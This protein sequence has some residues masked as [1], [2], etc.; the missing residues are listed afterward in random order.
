MSDD[1]SW[2]SQE[3]GILDYTLRLIPSTL[4]AT[5]QNRSMVLPVLQAMV[6][7][8]NYFYMQNRAAAGH[9]YTAAAVSL[10]IMCGL[11]KVNSSA[12]G[13]SWLP[14]A[15]PAE[16]SERINGWW[17]IYTLERAWTAVLERPTMINEQDNRT[18][19]DTPWPNQVFN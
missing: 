10:A 13:H 8:A 3:A 11:H 16:L 1:A 4:H 9:Y 15:G 6:L 7:L 2:T 5:Q 14:P 19:V 17:Q 12:N 18:A